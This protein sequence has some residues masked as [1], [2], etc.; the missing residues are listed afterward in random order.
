MILEILLVYMTIKDCL[1][2]GLKKSVIVT[3]VLL[4]GLNRSFI[5]AHPW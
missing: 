5:T 1:F 4:A 3:T 2:Q